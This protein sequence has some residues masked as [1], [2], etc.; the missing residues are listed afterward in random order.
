MVLDWGDRGT[1]GDPVDGVSEVGLDEEGGIGGGLELML[2]T[3]ELLVLSGA[4]VRHVIDTNGG[5]TSVLGVVGLDLG[6]LF[7][8]C[9]LVDLGG[10][11]GVSHI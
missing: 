4:L 9:G 1:L 7:C 3:K 6:V 5:H 11:V 8:E 2:V 10:V